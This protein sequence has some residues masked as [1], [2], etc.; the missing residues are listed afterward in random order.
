VG[1]AGVHIEDQVNLNHHCWLVCQCSRRGRTD[2]QSG[3]AR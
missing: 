1:A 3:R 2:A